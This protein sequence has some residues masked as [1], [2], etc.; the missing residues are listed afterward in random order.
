[1]VSKGHNPHLTEYGSPLL[2]C[3]SLKSTMNVNL[4]TLKGTPLSGDADKQAKTLSCISAQAEPPSCE[5]RFTGR[6]GPLPQQPARLPALSALT[7]VTESSGHQPWSCRC[8]HSA[9][10]QPVLAG[11]TESTGVPRLSLG[12][13]SAGLMQ[14]LV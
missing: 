6:V 7:G 10:T 9:W 3:S 1:M 14:L 4:L 12:W 11:V 2:P 13:L 8:H 5:W